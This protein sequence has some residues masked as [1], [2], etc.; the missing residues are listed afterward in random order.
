[1]PEGVVDQLRVCQDLQFNSSSQLTLGPMF[2]PETPKTVI[3]ADFHVGISMLV[4]RGVLDAE[5][6]FV[7]Q[8][9]SSLG[10]LIERQNELSGEPERLVQFSPLTEKPSTQIEREIYDAMKLAL[11]IQS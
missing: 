8:A 1:M 10:Q 5:S 11:E 9:L 6:A 2:G 7:K 3:A 4:N